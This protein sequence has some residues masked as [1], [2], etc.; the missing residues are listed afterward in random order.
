MDWVY[1]HNKKVYLLVRFMTVNSYKV[2]FNILM[3]LIIKEKLI[4]WW[5]RA[6]ESL[7]L[8]MG[9]SLR[10]TLV[11]ILLGKVSIKLRII[12]CGIKG[13]LIRI[14]RN[15]A[16]VN[17]WFGMWRSMKD[18]LLM[19]CLK[20]MVRLRIL[21]LIRLIRVASNRAWSMGLVSFMVRNHS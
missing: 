14:V 16:M 17:W 4:K 20:G 15:M 5:N 1:G 2:L 11:R 7:D 6:R 13:S 21:K 18:S 10:V 19:I 12:Q 3:V 8:L 9:I